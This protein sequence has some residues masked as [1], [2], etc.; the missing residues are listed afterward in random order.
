[1]QITSRFTIAVHILSCIDY[2]EGRETVTSNFLAGSVGA[3]PVIIRTVMLK[4]KAAGL[5]DIRQGKSGISLAKPL[6]EITFY[7]VYRAV[8][9]VDETGLFH[10]HE[11]PS[12][13]CPVGRRIHRAM[14]GRLRAIQDAMEAALRGMTVGDIAAEISGQ[15]GSGEMEQ[16]NDGTDDDAKRAA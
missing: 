6:G 16:R 12:L 10:F 8:N 9:C 5:I 4:L 3:N 7:D 2:F 11:N 1:M 15:A 13:S 14:D